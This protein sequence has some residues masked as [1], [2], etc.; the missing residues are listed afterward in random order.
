MSECWSRSTVELTERLKNLLTS[1]YSV[2][3]N[4]VKV[5][6]MFTVYTIEYLSFIIVVFCGEL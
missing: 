6:Q 5:V 3:L 2:C 1:K 4:L